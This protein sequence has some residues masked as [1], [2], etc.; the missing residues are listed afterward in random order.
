ML[1]KGNFHFT[2]NIT[3]NTS[4]DSIDGGNAFGHLVFLHVSINFV[5]L[6]G[7]P[8]SLLA[9]FRDT[10]SSKRAFNAFY[11]VSLVYFGMTD[12]EVI[13]GTFY[14]IGYA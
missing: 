3:I 13:K 1:V 11:S 4:W 10:P 12:G 5:V 6:F 8:Y 7:I 14:I 9:S 2:K